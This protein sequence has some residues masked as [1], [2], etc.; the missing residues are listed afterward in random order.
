MEPNTNPRPSALVLPTAVQLIEDDGPGRL[1][2]AE[3]RYDCS[4]PYAVS[5]AFGT[6]ENPVIWTFARDLLLDGQHEPSGDGDVHVWPDV[7]ETGLA[8]VMIELIADGVDVLVAVLRSDVGSF[9]EQSSQLV[10][11]GQESL[12]DD[13]D[14]AIAAILATVPNGR[15]D[16]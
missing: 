14:A 2:A 16:A 6:P 5:V 11:P 8:V 9:T 13:I 4:D 1:L 15:S 10:V 7:T 3:F 12:E